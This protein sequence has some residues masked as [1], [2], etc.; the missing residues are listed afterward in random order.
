MK[1][2]VLFCLVYFVYCVLLRN[3]FKQNKES[4][5]SKTKSLYSEIKKIYRNNCN[6]FRSKIL[7]RNTTLLKFILYNLFTNI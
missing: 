5:M 6:L 3:K 1:N 4:K 7:F 2:T